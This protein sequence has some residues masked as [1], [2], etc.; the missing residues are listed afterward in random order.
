MTVEYP[1]SGYFFVYGGN[2]MRLDVEKLSGNPKVKKVTA[3]RIDLTTEF[4]IDLFKLL[5]SGKTEEIKEKLSANGLGDEEVYKGY[6]SRL[7]LALEMNG[8]PVYQN[9]E[10]TQMTDY[11]EENPLL[12]SGKFKRRQKGS[13]GIS[14]DPEF[15]KQLFSI[16]PDVPV[17]EGLRLAGIDPID[18]GS[19]RIYRINEKFS[20]KANRLNKATGDQS[21]EEKEEQNDEKAV[22][23]IS[24]HPYIKDIKN[25]TIVLSEAFFNETYLL[26]SVPI[27]DLLKAY[28]LDV[29]CFSNKDLILIR[30]QQVHWSPVEVSDTIWNDRVLAIQRKRYYLLSRA[31]A[32]GFGKIKNIVPS[33]PIEKRRGLSGW[34]SELP[35]DP[36]GFYTTK[37]VL[38]KVGISKSVHYELLSNED[39]GNGIRKKELQ[40]DEDIAIVRQVIDYKGFA[41]GIRQVYMLMPKVAGKQ[42]SIHRIRRLMQKYGI[43]TN[44]RRP[45]RNRK[46]MKE[47]IERNRKSNLL[48]RRFRL[49]RPNEVRLTDV[50]YL[51]YGD[52]KRAYGSA[53][54]DPATGKL[55]CFVVSRNNDLQLAL[56]TLDEMDKYPAKRGAIFHSDQGILYMTDDFQ[57]AVVERELDQSMSRRGNCWD[58]APQEAF[59]G[60][61]KDESGYEKCQTLKELR[62]TVKRYAVYYN[63]ERKIWDRGRMTPVEYEEW[64]NA[65]SESEFQAYLE[66]EEEKYK[67]TKEESAKKAIKRARE[68][69]EDTL[70]AL[71]ERNETGKA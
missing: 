46:A 5:R 39:Y 66:A 61:F 6:C 59:F 32:D 22:H 67:K 7:T 16:Y 31:V 63:E 30:S 18:V 51:D 28:E 70:A 27:G 52:G 12:T 45:S 68:Y 64:L 23:D 1:S 44:I 55:I 29:A 33:L 69:R 42:F 36:Q 20:A 41:K 71:E 24:R 10:I 25:G 4:R 48:L 56:D 57:A 9:D 26:D 40:D 47:L 50:T 15:E 13:R 38:E 62:D 65:M 58:N 54:I 2:D 34:I 14:I 53:S 35:K 43:E 17:E 11:I 19:A 60:H 8:Y 37:R 49:H 21:Y 3:N